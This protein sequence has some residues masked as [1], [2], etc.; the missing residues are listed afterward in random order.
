MSKNYILKKLNTEDLFFKIFNI[1]KGS[2]IN[3]KTDFEE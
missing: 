1:S 2:N 3:H